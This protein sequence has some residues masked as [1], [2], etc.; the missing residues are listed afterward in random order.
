MRTQVEI[1]ERQYVVVRRMGRR[2]LLEELRGDF[3]DY[4]K[5]LGLIQGQM[6]EDLKISQAA[7]S[8]LESGEITVSPKVMKLVTK[9]LT[10]A[11][12]HK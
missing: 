3:S 10:K 12:K 8:K 5:K 2:L 7:V 1:N 9:L 11:E 6:A 4:R